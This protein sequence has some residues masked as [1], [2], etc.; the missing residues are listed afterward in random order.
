MAITVDSPKIVFQNGV[1][2]AGDYRSDSVTKLASVRKASTLIIFGMRVIYRTTGEGTFFCPQC[3][4]GRQYRL[5]V[6]RRWFTL[7][8]IPVIPMNKVGEYVECTT[9]R[10]RYRPDVLAQPAQS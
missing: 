10:T 7:F 4:T 2:D 1:D 3:G 5:R 6:G 8:F 9:C